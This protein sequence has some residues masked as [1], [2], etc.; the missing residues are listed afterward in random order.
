MRENRAGGAREEGGRS[1]E[2]KEIWGRFEHLWSRKD[3][4]GV[5]QI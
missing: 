4:E 2:C 5:E 3:T 1:R